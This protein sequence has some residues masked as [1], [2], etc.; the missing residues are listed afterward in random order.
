MGIRTGNPVGPVVRYSFIWSVLSIWGLLVLSCIII[1]GVTTSALA[2]GDP[3]W[4]VVGTGVAVMLLGLIIF[5][6]N[7]DVS[8]MPVWRFAIVGMSV[9]L[10]CIMALANLFILTRTLFY[11]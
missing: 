8:E 1:A 11:P 4:A 7:G 2:G 9:V 6:I 5:L 3:P 10:M